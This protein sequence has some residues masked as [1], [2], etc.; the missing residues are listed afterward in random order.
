M[1]ALV[2]WGIVSFAVLQI[3]EPI[4]HALDL[5]DWTLK[6]VVAALAIGFP[7]TA[8]LAWAFDLKTTGIERTQPSPEAPTGQGASLRGPRLAI[9]LLGLGAAAA[10]PG[11]VYFFVWRGPGRQ[12]SE[13]GGGSAAQAAPSIAVL[14]FADMSEKHDQEYFADGVAEE[15]LNSLARVKGLKV[16]GRTSSF[17]FKGKAEDL[18]VIGQKLDVANVLEGSLRRSG[19]RVRITAQL[20]KAADGSHLWSETFDRQVDDIFKVQDDI[21]AAVTRS[22]EVRLLP[23]HES[24]G[25]RTSN[26][27]AYRL[28]VIGRQAARTA[29]SDAD[30]Q[31]AI[32]VLER[33]VNLDPGYAPAQALLGTAV[34]QRLS[35][36]ST[37]AM[38]TEEWK[39]QWAWPLA[40]AEKAIAL[41]PDLADG[42]ILRASYRSW[43][44]QDWAGAQTDFE[45]AMALDHGS[46]SGRREYA[47]LHA[48]L[49]RL[50]E[51]LR[52]AQENVDTDPLDAQSWL[53]LGVFQAA[54]GHPEQAE[55]TY[56]RGLEVEPR[57]P[58][59]LRQLGFAYLLQG[60]GQQAL[61]L[62]QDHPIEYMR[63]AGL[64][65][66]H[67]ALHQDKEAKRSIDALAALGETYW[68]AVP[69]AW[70]GDKDR[71]F[72]WLERGLRV[73]DIAM[74][75]IRFDPFLNGLRSDQRYSAL[76]KKM[77]LPVD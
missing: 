55:G 77:N 58:H 75:Y 6:L 36:L 33:G 22:L 48:S 21:A 57:E 61:D 39:T 43:I 16:I 45:R 54:T 41:A 34:L 8:V 63:Q 56:Q 42:Y 5:P 35:M 74:R 67:H 30:F 37:S 28:Y 10:A 26:P 40:L 68:V 59:L 14:P 12:P 11:L 64:A 47:L 53:W 60:R 65:L 19:N 76:L 9:L 66:A 4:M 2:G 20:I 13:T 52:M 1:R 69:Y 31:R 29:V 49:G 38:S 32:D 23:E 73:K 18:R 44:E 24:A 17:Y 46:V 27:E 70:M 25:A 62:F 72:Q 71:A 50:G 7:I 51:A 3:V 15:V